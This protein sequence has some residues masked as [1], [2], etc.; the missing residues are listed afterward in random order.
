MKGINNIWRHSVVSLLMIG[1]ASCAFA[2]NVVFT[3]Q[4]SA[5][6]MGIKDNVQVEYTIRDAQNVQTMTPPASNDF[7]VV[8]GPYTTHSVNS[9]F[10]GRTNVTSESI[11]RTYV[12]H[13]RRE[14]TLTIPPVIAKDAEGHTY[15]S[16]AVVIQVVPGTLAQQRRAQQQDPFGGDDALAMMQRMNQQMQQL[17]QQMMQPQPQQQ[18]QQQQQTQQPQQHAQADAA[19]EAEIKKNMFIKVEVDKT[20]VHVGEQITTS[21]KLYVRDL[22]MNASISKL[23]SL[24]GFWTQDF[25]IPRQ[26]KPEIEELDGKKYQVFLL[27]KSALFPQQTGTLELDPAEARGVARIVKQERHKMSDMFRGTLMMNDPAFNNSYYN[28][29]AYKD[30]EWKLESTPVKI[31]VT[32]LPEKDKTADYGGAVGKFSIGSKIDK[33]E[34]TT[35]DIATLT[36]TI[37]GSGNLKLIEPPKLNLPNGLNT[38]DP[39]ITDTITGRSTT[40]SGSKI[41]TYVISPHSPGDYEIPATS[42]TYFNP[43]TGAYITAHTQPFKLQVKAGKRYTPVA[44]GHE[45]SLKDIHDIAKVPLANITLRS[46]PLLFTGTYWSMF[47]FPLL[48]FIGLVVWKRRDEELSKNTVLLRSK[49]ANKV[50]LQ[51][52]ATAKTYLQQNE[53]TPFYEEISKATWLYLSDKLNI[54]LSALSRDTAA[55]AMSTRNVPGAVQKHLEDVIWECETAL[56]ASGGSQKMAYIYDEAIKVISDLEDVFKA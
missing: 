33:Q 7:D 29:M 25:E 39:Q 42:F 22:A 11:T 4:A 37:T 48:A 18:Q 1:I 53:K 8:G 31:T 45:N 56:Y 32:A 38:F 17:Q 23:P 35:D 9:S 55:E 24:N 40:I 30:V 43:Q 6:R 51:R 5:G 13:P 34:L 14:G 3:G 27:K 26:P 47:A 16:N 21:Y 28:T 15:Q 20:K 12:M 36:L 10:N 19:D 46:K 52:L 44:A 49:R 41:I 54:P 2:P 50:A